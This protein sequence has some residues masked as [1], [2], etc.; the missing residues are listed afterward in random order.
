MSQCTLYKNLYDVNLKLDMIPWITC[1]DK[2]SDGLDTVGFKG[3][4][5]FNFL[6]FLADL[7]SALHFLALE[8]GTTGSCTSNAFFE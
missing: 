3:L 1:I 8:G 6:F 5:G 2:S 7:T 4:A